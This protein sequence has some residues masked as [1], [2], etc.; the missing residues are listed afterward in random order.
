[1]SRDPSDAGLSSTRDA[2][3]TTTGRN[4]LSDELRGAG[5]M[6]GLVLIAVALSVYA[7]GGYGFL[8]ATAVG[9]LG[10]AVLALSV[11]GHAFRESERELAVVNAGDE[12]L[13]TQLRV[14][15]QNGGTDRVVYDLDLAPGERTVVASPF[16]RSEPYELT[17]PT[18]G[19]VARAEFVPPVPTETDADAPVATLEV[20]SESIR[21]TQSGSGEQAMRSV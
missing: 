15:P 8:T 20:T 11:P 2:R 3:W 10:V 14:A 12:Q 21:C 4:R 16:E 6:L 13:R 1:M 18:T 5:L 19:G 9:I 7:S 17:V